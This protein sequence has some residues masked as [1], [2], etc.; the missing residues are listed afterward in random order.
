M[1]AVSP[2]EA[3]PPKTTSVPTQPT[4][5][6]P[7]LSWFEQ[8]GVWILLPI[9]AWLA[10][11]ELGGFNRSADGRM[12]RRSTE[13]IPATKL[14]LPL[15][16]WTHFEAGDHS[17]SVRMPG[18][19]HPSVELARKGNGPPT[20]TWS[21]VFDRAP[22]GMGDLEF[23][24]T[25]FA[26]PSTDHLNKFRGALH[27]FTCLQAQ[28]FPDLQKC[29]VRPIRKNGA[30][31][32]EYFLELGDSQVVRQAYLNG[33][34]VFYVSCIGSNLEAYRE[35]WRLFLDSFEF[36]RSETPHRQPEPL[37]LPK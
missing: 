4:P 14:R 5:R 16:L 33:L 20:K 12:E 7:I 18:T 17:F 11:N 23:Q 27:W 3:N 26:I 29:V 25:S 6:L 30:D 36:E 37:P 10:W 15:R 21:V 35:D 13:F 1:Q 34:S 19:P 2:P 8:R 22:G 9:T 28:D 24:V 32:G 31:G